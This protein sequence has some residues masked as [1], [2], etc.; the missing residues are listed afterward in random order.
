MT[1]LGEISTL[2]NCKIA[3]LISNLLD[4]LS[5]PVIWIKQVTNGGCTYC[6]LFD[7]PEQPRSSCGVA[8]YSIVASSLEVRALPY[9]WFFPKQ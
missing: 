9:L 7:F 4:S 1:E 3:L 8:S 5:K 6:T 2:F